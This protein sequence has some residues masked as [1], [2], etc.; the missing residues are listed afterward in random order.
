MQ[1][2]QPGGK[3]GIIRTRGFVDGTVHVANHDS[4]DVTQIV[5]AVMRLDQNIAK[6]SEGLAV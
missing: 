5:N 3:G 4:I 6:A 1:A 2:P